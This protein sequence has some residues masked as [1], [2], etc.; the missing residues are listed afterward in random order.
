MELFSSVIGSLY[1]ILSLSI[2]CLNSLLLKTVLQHKEFKTGTYRIIKHMFVASLMQLP[3]FFIG[4]LMTIWQSTFN[5]Y[6]ERVLGVVVESTWF[7]YLGLSLTLAIDRLLIFATPNKKQLNAKI[8][9]GFL[10]ASWLLWVFL[11]VI[12]STPTLGYEYTHYYLW[13]FTQRSGALIM[14]YIEAYF[15][16]IFLA[17]I[18]LVYML[19]LAFLVKMKAL[20]SNN[21]SSKAELRIFCAAMLSFLY[22]LLFVCW[23]F[24]VPLMMPDQTMLM[25]ISSNMLWIF[26]CGLFASVMLA[27]NKNLRQKLIETT[28]R[29]KKS[30]I[31]VLSLARG[32]NRK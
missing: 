16:P 10:A 32:Q 5:F 22:E 1:S 23:T 20:A 13:I 30:T 27:F 21:T 8:T 25:D 28:R 9:L 7:L 6:L 14:A 31:T 12:Q 18:L 26:D 24:W 2:F 3:S 4:G 19:V 11:V 17:M 29:S 15:D